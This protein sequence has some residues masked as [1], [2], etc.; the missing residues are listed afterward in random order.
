MGLVRLEYRSD[1]AICLRVLVIFGQRSRPGRQHRD[2]VPPLSKEGDRS[3]ASPG[4][5]LVQNVIVVT[6]LIILIIIVIRV[7]VKKREKKEER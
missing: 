1:L 4:G 6:I 7:I 3:R 5:V 2:P